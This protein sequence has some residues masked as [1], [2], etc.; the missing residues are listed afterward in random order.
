MAQRAQS[1]LVKVRRDLRTADG[2]W[3]YWPAD[4]TDHEKL[5]VE[6]MLTEK[7]YEVTHSPTTSKGVSV[8]ARPGP[9]PLE[10]VANISFPEDDDI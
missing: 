1:A 8:R 6:R 4:I 2:T 3:L 7:G 10:T 9:S 5:E